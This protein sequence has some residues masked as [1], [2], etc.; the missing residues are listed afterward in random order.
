MNVT[1]HPEGCLILYDVGN[2]MAWYLC[3]FHCRRHSE[4]ASKA[5][6]VSHMCAF[7]KRKKMLLFSCTFTV[8]CYL[9]KMAR[10]YGYLLGSATCMKSLGECVSVVRLRVFV[11][12]QHSG[13]VR[14]L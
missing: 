8:I 6:R 3:C 9:K 14:R 2:V 13:W 11:V 12:I 10:S 5:E 1:C 7:E 4:K